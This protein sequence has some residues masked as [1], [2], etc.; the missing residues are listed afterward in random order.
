MAAAAPT[1]PQGRSSSLHAGIV[2]LLPGLLTTAALAAGAIA[3]GKLLY[4]SGASPLMI[5][6]ALG[7][8]V[9]WL[10]GT[11]AAMQPGIQF[12]QKRLLR[13]AIVLLGLQLTFEQIWAVG[14]AVLFV[15]IATVLITFAFSYWI[16]R[17]LQVEARL[18]QL[19]AAGTSICGISAIVASNAVVKA[20]DEDVAYAIATATAFGSVSI[21]IY[22]LLADILA[23]EPTLYAI[24]AGSSLH[25]V[26]QV[27]A[28]GFTYGEEAGEFSVVVKLTRVLMLVPM[29]LAM[30]WTVR[31]TRKDTAD[32]GGTALGIIR[33]LPLPLFVAGFVAM[34]AINSMGWIPAGPHEAMTLVSAFFFAMALTALGL[35]TDLRKLI[36]KGPRPLIAAALAWLFIS[37]FSL[38]AVYLL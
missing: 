15:I 13:I 21:F 33:N 23:L 34:I 24:W 10:A 8:A 5:A 20:S 32:T 36:D 16:C 19:I 22:P 38:A 6:I 30:A 31:I 27:I 2:T 29:V 26:A 25:E 12:A 28:A 3:T 4:G 37:G 11:R 17:C 1:E 14:G 7:V 35:E 18:A 9:R